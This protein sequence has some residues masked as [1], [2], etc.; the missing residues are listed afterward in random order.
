MVDDA[1]LRSLIETENPTW[2]PRL[3]FEGQDFRTA[4]NL[5]AAGL[6]TALLPQLLL[7]DLPAGVVALP[8]DRTT[9]VRRL[10]TRRLATRNVP[11]PIAQLEAHL[12]DAA[13]GLATRVIVT[14]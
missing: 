7:H 2:T 3:D 12:R 5:V 4:L 11:T 8:M 6:G 13:A 10:F 9:L 14:A 1:G